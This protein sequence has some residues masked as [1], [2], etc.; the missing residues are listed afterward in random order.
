[1]ITHLVHAHLQ[2][3]ATYILNF[4]RTTHEDSYLFLKERY[5]WVLPMSVTVLENFNTNQ[6]Y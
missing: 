2:Q 6:I 1:M 5:L 4:K 3:L